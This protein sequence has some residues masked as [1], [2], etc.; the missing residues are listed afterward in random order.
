MQTG[1]ILRCLAIVWVSVFFL[2]ACTER[3]SI[4]TEDAA[5]RLIIYGYIT[6]ETKSHAIRITRSTG[7]FATTR[8]PAISRATV[9]LSDGENTFLLTEDPDEPGTYLTETNVY[10]VEGKTYSLYVAV[11]FDGDGIDEEYEAVSYLPFA[12]EIDEVGLRPAEYFD[13]R[14]EVLFTGRLPDNEENFLSIYL[15]RNDV[16]ITD[17]LVNFSIID[18][19]YIDKKELENVPCYYMDQEKENFV[20]K[21]GDKVTLQVNSI[22]EEYARFLEDAQ[23]ELHGSNP[24]F[25]GPPA[26]IPSNVKARDN[27]NQTPISGFFSAYSFCQ[28]STVYQEE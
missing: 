10:G 5:E 26:N 28:G 4:R 14:I 21:N 1:N 17:S 6:T 18:D 25:G 7:Y 15:Y 19:E 8:P 20:L 2:S 23:S 13:D 22:T 16:W 24:L 12:A 11:D 27:R 3:I 9:T